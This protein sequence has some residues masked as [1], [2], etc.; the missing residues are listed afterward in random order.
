VSVT[1]NVLTIKEVPLSVTLVDGGGA[2]SEDAVVTVEPS[3]V[4]LS[5][6]AEVMNGINKLVLGTIDLSTVDASYS[7]TYTIILPNDTEI[8]SGVKEAKVTVEIKGLSTKKLTVTNFVCDGVTSGYE[9]EVITESLEVTVRAKQEIL[10]KIKA[11]NLRAVAD[12]TDIGETV[13][14]FSPAVKVFIDGFPSAGV[15]GPYKISVSLSTS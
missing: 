8:L 4:S 12:L 1:L 10:D 2:T 9:A 14:V 13:G 15:V 11:D 6:A 7:Q 5:G 3:T